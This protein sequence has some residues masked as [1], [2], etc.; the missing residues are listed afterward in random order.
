MFDIKKQKPALNL[1]EGV[2]NYDFKNLVIYVDDKNEDADALKNVM[3]YDHKNNNK[4]YSSTI[5]DSGHIMNAEEGQYL[6]MKLYNGH[7][8][9]Q[10]ATSEEDPYPFIRINFKEWNRVF[11]LSE[12]DLKATDENIFK[13]HRQMLSLTQLNNKI[14]TIKIKYDK[15][16]LQ[17]DEFVKNK[18]NF[19]LDYSDLVKQDSIKKAKEREK[20]KVK[21][22]RKSKNIPKR[23][24]KESFEQI[25]P[26]E[27]AK[28]NNMIETFVKKDR[29]RIEDKVYSELRGMV[30]QAGTAMRNLRNEKRNF[31]KYIYEYHNRY[32]TAIICII[33]F[34]IGAPLGAIIR[35][36]GFGYPML[37][38][39]IFFVAYIMTR[40]M[41][42]KLVKEALIN[43]IW[44]AWAPV[45]FLLP[46]GI[47]FTYMA[48][49]DK[50]LLQ[51]PT[52]PEWLM[53]RIKGVST[54]S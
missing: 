15:L 26:E 44:A 27:I 34:L 4:N 35:K 32:A 48:L 31:E 14:D 17:F 1:D 52:M 20:Y 18:M 8:Y 49:N 37:M 5:A 50:K 41:F 36:G 25:P 21:E 38:A 24:V 10:G 16:Q 53:K 13:S 46:V 42:E 47:F 12:F 39:I 51:L 22:I 40:I 23:L 7:Q 11:D 29:R 43:P 3:I 2:F 6:L 9:T 33:F 28:A 45:A 19:Y 54:Q 30:S